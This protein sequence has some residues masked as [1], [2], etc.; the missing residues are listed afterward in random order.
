[1]EVF[2]NNIISFPVVVYTFLLVVII[3]YWLLALLG[4]VDIDMFDLD[5]DIDTGLETDM[6]AEGLSGVTGFML[7]WGL[8][9]VPVTVVISILVASA[10]LVCYAVVSL[11]FPLLPWDTLRGVMGLALLLISFALAIPITAQF[12]KPIKQVFVSHTAANKASF[13]GSECLVKTGS[14]TETFGQA[15]YEDGGAG[16][17]FDIRAATADGIKKGDLVVLKKYDEESGSYWV[18]K[19]SELD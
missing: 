6:D 18:I 9:G 15:E 19:T 8:T 1:M 7:K 12:I 13:I 5:L 16:M 10:W 3:C 14:V 2:L 17:L 11:V 4:A